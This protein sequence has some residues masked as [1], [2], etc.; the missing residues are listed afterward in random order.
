MADLSNSPMP[1][2]GAPGP[3][4]KIFDEVLVLPAA[5]RVARLKQLCGDDAPLLQRVERLLQSHE[6]AGG[7][8]EP[9]LPP[10]PH[11]TM[12]ISLP[13]DEKPGDVIGRYK[14]REK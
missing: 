6:K 11:P 9:S 8:L 14:I 13:V 10:S 2:S 4:E 7:F 12:M 5:E 1:R 3:E